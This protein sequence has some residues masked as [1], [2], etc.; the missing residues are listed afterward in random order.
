MTF[1]IE[2][3][4]NEHVAFGFGSHFCLGSSLARLELTVAFETLLDRLPDLRLAP[5]PNP[6]TVRR[7]S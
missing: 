6:P 2:R 7:T 3:T 4:P 1:D 5:T